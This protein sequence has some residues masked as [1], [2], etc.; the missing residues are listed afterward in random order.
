M[1]STKDIKYVC[2][3]KLIQITTLY[4]FGAICFAN[5]IDI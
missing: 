3:T 2:S 5:E 1:S 4:G